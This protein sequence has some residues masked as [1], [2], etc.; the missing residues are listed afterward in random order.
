M[1]PYILQLKRLRQEGYEFKATAG[2]YNECE[3]GWATQTLLGW[4]KDAVR[5]HAIAAPASAEYTVQVGYASSK[6]S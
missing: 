2:L 5:T 6:H 3:V 4:E 1:I